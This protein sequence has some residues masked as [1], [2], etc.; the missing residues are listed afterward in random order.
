MP[1]FRTGKPFTKLQLSTTI[2]QATGTTPVPWDVLAY[3]EGPAMWDPSDPTKIVI[4]RTGTYLVAVQWSRSAPSVADQTNVACLVNGTV[5]MQDRPVS[6]AQL[7]AGNLS[8]PLR[9]ETADELEVIT[10]TTSQPFL[11]RGPPS[12]PSAW[13]V[14]RIGPERWT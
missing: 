10:V 3:E 5:V 11:L 13:S 14:I 7:T 8:Q 12:T 6:V 2:S 4:P 1:I 9:L